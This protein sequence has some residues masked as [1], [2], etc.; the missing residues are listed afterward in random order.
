[1]FFF[2]FH[3]WGL[4]LNQILKICTKFLKLKYLIYTPLVSGDLQEEMI[5]GD[6][7]VVVDSPIDGVKDSM[8]S[9]TAPK[10]I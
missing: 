10:L 3:Q 6:A 9:L 5:L 7:V 2:K 8:M 1:M 4:R